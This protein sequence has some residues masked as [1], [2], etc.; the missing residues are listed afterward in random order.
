VRL[1]RAL[2]GLQAQEKDGGAQGG[3]R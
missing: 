1:E 3:A 2:K